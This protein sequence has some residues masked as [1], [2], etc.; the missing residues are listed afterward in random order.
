MSRPLS[1]ACATLRW[2]CATPVGAGYPMK[3]LNLAPLRRFS[4]VF[5]NLFFSKNP[6]ARRIPHVQEVGSE[7]S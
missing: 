1:P 7:E 2:P 5:K 3:L 6:F 4:R